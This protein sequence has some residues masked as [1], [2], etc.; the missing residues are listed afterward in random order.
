MLVESEQVAPLE[1]ADVAAAEDPPRAADEVL[2]VGLGRGRIGGEIGSLLQK[3]SSS[4]DDGHLGTG[5]TRGALGKGVRQQPRVCAARESG[6]NLVGV[7]VRSAVEDLEERAGGGTGVD[8]PIAPGLVDVR[9]QKRQQ[10][11]DLL[12]DDVPVHVGRVEGEGA[13]GL[14][15]IG[16]E[17][18][19]AALHLAGALVTKLREGRSQGIPATT[20]RVDDSALT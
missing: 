19:L 14:T 8:D 5:E 3:R 20:R 4:G 12:V 7:V 10:L 15:L 6:E 18:E 11:L 2:H 9:V 13:V 17:P 1:D 16:A